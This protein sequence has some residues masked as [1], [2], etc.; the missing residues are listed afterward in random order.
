MY[1][2]IAGPTYNTGRGTHTQN[3]IEVAVMNTRCCYRKVVPGL[4]SL[5]ESAADDGDGDDVTR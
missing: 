2:G 4:V 3:S 1:I 5:M